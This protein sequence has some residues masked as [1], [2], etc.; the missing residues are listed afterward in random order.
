MNFIIAIIFW[1]IGLGL[2]SFTLIPVLIIFVFAIPITR[3]L[4]KAGALRVNNGIIRRY[5]ISLIILSLTFLTITG[6]TFLF[7]PNAMIALVIGMGMAILS[8]LGKTGKNKNNVVDYLETNKQYL[9]ISS[10]EALLL[11]IRGST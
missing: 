10:E 3:K 7:I 5:M 11:I 1:F 6:I 2:A 8:G 9:G 4:E